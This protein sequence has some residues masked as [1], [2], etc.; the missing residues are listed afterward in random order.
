MFYKV[1]L[2]TK[3]TTYSL[4][5]E[6]GFKTFMNILNAKPF[7]AIDYPEDDKDNIY[8]SVSD[9]TTT[10]FKLPINA[11]IGF[12]VVNKKNL[13][14]VDENTI[15]IYTD[16]GGSFY[17]FKINKRWENNEFLMNKLKRYQITND[18]KTNKDLFNVNCLTYA[19]MMSGKF[20]DKF[21]DNFKLKCY[22]RYIS[23]K[24]LDKLG[25]EE[26]INI[27]FNVKKIRQDNLN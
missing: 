2:I 5:N 3:Y 24:A 12:R 17:P 20:D 15:K 27:R 14:R 8:I 16:N 11:I 26:D 22:T 9:D 13:S 1:G 18:L 21:I 4:N 23:H 10:D 25:K 19:L 7:D 6:Q